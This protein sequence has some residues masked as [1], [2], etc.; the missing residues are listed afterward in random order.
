MRL[1]CRTAYQVRPSPLS[2][3]RAVFG[4][5]AAFAALS[6]AS[7]NAAAADAVKSTQPSKS[8]FQ[9]LSTPL[10]AVPNLAPYMRF[11]YPSALSAPLPLPATLGLPLVLMPSQSYADP[12]GLLG[13][14]QSTG[15]VWTSGNAFFQSL[16][17]NGRSCFSCHQPSNGM[18]L[19]TST[20]KTLF[21]LTGG[22]DPVFAPVDG[23]NCPKSVPRTETVASLLNG[24]L[25]GGLQSK[26]DSHSLLL[27]K[28]LFRIFLPVPTRT[29]DFTAFGGPPSHEVEFTITVESDP[30]GCNTDP[31]YSTQIDPVTQ[32][33]RQMISVY[34]RPRM[35]GNLKFLNPALTT[36][37]GGQIPN[38]DFVTGMPVVD[39]S[40]GAEI[41]G[42]IMWD[43]REPTLESQARNATLGHAQALKPP[44]DAQIAQMVEYEKSVFVAQRYSYQAGDLTQGPTSYVFGG[45]EVMAQKT[46]EFGNFTL[47][48]GWPT[49]TGSFATTNQK[50]RASIARG[51]ALF[52][53]RAISVGNVAGFNNATLLGVT[54]PLST[55]CSSCHGNQ[56]AGNDPF[57]NGQR[58][59]GTGGHAT[60]YGGP[61]PATDLPIFKISCKP[62]YTTPFLGTEVRTND[63]GMALI[64][65]RCDDI[66]RKSVPQLRAM[67]A[68]APFFSDG[69]AATVGD[70]I[71]F[72][73]KRF[74]IGFTPSE[75]T[76]LTNFL[77]AL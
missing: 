38:I 29:A 8:K 24:L 37:G 20:I 28:G 63:P 30:Y 49:T 34:R 68:R 10:P 19:N 59:I 73:D 6:M 69:S 52:N 44:T 57:S 58:D 12:K 17:T 4:A 45:P 2:P 25:G 75:V 67:A 50:A 40:T 3:A 11:T 36:L 77:E 9:L 54:N 13:V 43:G 53:T 26:R 32:E 15:I 56:Q 21:A 48:N 7:S 64:T 76:D 23:A 72:Y 33:Q 22:R 5:L 35:S 55:T 70:V 51:Q 60:L 31:A 66:G 71:R 47:Y 74:T 18:S 39:P 14:Y 65:G 62:G 41:S 46:V 61:P 1:T 27:D 16:G 42:N